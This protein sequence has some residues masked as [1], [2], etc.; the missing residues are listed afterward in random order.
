MKVN[1]IETLDLES[2]YKVLNSKEI[3]EAQKT[4][5]VLS[6]STNIKKIMKRSIDDKDFKLL[7]KNRAIKKFRP[8]KNSY[9]KIGDKMILAKALSL[10]PSKLPRYIKNVTQMMKDSTELDFLP[11]STL[12]T[13]FANKPVIPKLAITTEIT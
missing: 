2:I 9:T 5:F 1:R 10:Q 11:K 12:E 8:I 6:N 7:M 4:K 3:T 13:M